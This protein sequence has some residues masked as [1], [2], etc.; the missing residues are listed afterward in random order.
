LEAGVPHSVI[1]REVLQQSNLENAVEA[2]ERASRAVSL[3]YLIADET[4]R[5]CNVEATPSGCD[6]WFAKNGV[7]VHTNH[8]LSRNLAFRK[9]MVL[10]SGISFGLDTEFRYGRMSD[11]VESNA[12]NVTLTR[13]FDFLRDHS[14]H[15]SSI[16]RHPNP[17]EPLATRSRTMDSLVMV[18]AKRE[19]WIAHGNPCEN[20]F[21]KY[22]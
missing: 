22:A 16:C 6:K 4:G 14:N 19:M 7:L 8:I 5:A 11:L 1:M 21:L 3:N 10:A 12:G 2:I 18:P 20:E 9:D 15:P 13:M 17:A